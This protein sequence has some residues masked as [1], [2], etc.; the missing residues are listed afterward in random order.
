MGPAVGHRIHASRYQAELSLT[1]FC[2][3]PENQSRVL[4]SPAAAHGHIETD[5]LVDIEFSCL[6]AEIRGDPPP[7]GSQLVEQLDADVGVAREAQKKK[8]LE[9][10]E[11]IIAVE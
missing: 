6:I 10:L 4:S 5:R 2:R 9:K 11:L 7:D 1:A 8:H 3:I